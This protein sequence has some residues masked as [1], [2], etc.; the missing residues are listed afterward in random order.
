MIV[1]V[2]AGARLQCPFCTKACKNRNV[3][4]T[5]IS[6]E[7]AHRAA[8]T[9]ADLAI[10]KLLKATH[11][12]GGVVEATEDAGVNV[13]TTY[14]NLRCMRLPKLLL[15]TLLLRHIWPGEAALSTQIQ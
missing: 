11:I 5:H 7:H 9:T 14:P 10:L 4:A 13:A 8:P 15:H 3:L 12:Y 2:I 6:R 1:G